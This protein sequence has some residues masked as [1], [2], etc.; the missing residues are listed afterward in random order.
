MNG[1]KDGFVDGWREGRREG[2]LNV[3]MLDT[4]G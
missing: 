1:W 3:G 2:S 4:A